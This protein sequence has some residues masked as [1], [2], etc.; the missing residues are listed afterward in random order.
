MRH[1]D[2]GGEGGGGIGWEA[3]TNDVLKFRKA[4]K[5]ES[6]RI[7]ICFSYIYPLSMEKDRLLVK[8]VVKNLGN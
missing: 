6:S 8:K 2:A 4:I 3:I 7:V 1:N 5:F